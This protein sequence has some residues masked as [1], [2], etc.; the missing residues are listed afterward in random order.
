MNF[1][2]LYIA[3]QQGIV[4]AQENPYEI[5]WSSKFY[6]VQ[7]YLVNTHHICF[8]LS[9]VMNKGLYDSMPEEYQKI[10]DD[11]MRDAGDLLFENAKDNNEELLAK[12]VHQSIP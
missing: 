2:E 11:S 5:V 8:I 4:D 10:V 12:I 1:A 7:K 3:L 6:E 9:I